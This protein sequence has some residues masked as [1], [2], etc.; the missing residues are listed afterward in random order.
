MRKKADLSAG[1]VLLVTA[2]ILVRSFKRRLLRAVPGIGAHLYWAKFARGITAGGGGRVLVC[3][4]LWPA[5]EGRDSPTERNGW[6][7]QKAELTEECTC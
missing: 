2:I 4:E 6:L 1:G 7:K 3:G 5:E